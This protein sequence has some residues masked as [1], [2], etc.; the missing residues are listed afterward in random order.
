MFYIYVVFVY[1]R[2]GE[3][4]RIFIFQ[5]LAGSDVITDCIRG[6]GR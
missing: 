3:K 6:W 1:M 4:R 5:L 2:G